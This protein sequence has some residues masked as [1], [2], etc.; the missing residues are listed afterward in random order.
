VEEESNVI[1]KEHVDLS[2][3]S[4]RAELVQR[5]IYRNDTELSRI[6]NT[7]DPRSTQRQCSLTLNCR[8][9]FGEKL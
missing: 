4:K 5:Y 1:R 6:E 7:R 3:E 2:K 8:I 9:S